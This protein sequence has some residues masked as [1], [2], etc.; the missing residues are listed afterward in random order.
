MQPKLTSPVPSTSDCTGSRPEGR[1]PG[2]RRSLPSAPEQALQLREQAARQAARRFPNPGG[3]ASCP[4][5]AGQI[6][7][8]TEA[9]SHHRGA[10]DESVFGSG[11]EDDR[12][13][14][15]P[16][17]PPRTAS[18]S[19]PAATP[20]TAA[21]ITIHRGS[22]FPTVWDIPR[23]RDEG[24]FLPHFPWRGTCSEIYRTIF[25]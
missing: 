11:S 19:P 3:G 6:S 23:W 15:L 2:R 13:Y 22:S 4:A 18:P 14:P 5:L 7:S 24:T 1:P 16:I 17:S 8:A 9:I 21:N 10:D 12:V 20:S 25:L